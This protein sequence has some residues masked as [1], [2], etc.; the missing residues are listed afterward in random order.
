[1]QPYHECEPVRQQARRTQ[2]LGLRFMNLEA[3]YRPKYS[4]LLGVECI[5]RVSLRVYINQL[6]LRPL[7]VFFLFLPL[8]VYNALTRI[9]ISTNQF[10]SAP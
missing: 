4:P 2:V 10:C 7:L 3:I 5:K 8:L 6:A 1:M 9:L